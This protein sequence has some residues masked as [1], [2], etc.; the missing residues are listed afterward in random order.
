MKYFNVLMTVLTLI[1]GLQ[2]PVFAESSASE[3][4]QLLSSYRR[5][6]PLEG[7]SNFRDVGGYPTADGK[8]VARGLIFRSGA[9]TSLSESD[10]EYLQQF[11]FKAVVD[12]RSTDER[13]LFVNK[14]AAQQDIPIISRDYSLVK[15]LAKLREQMKGQRMDLA[16]TYPGLLENI[17]PQLKSMFNALLEERTPLVFNCSAGQD[18]TGTTAAILLT[19][20]GV[21][22]DIVIEDYLLST[23]FRRPDRENGDVDLVAAAETNPF[24][25]MM[26]AYKKRSAHPERPNSLISSEGIPY[27]EYTFAWIDENYGSLDNYLESELGLGEEQL[28]KLKTLY[29]L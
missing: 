22:H 3:R 11:D 18:R 17:K 16:A 26:L 15:D 10:V 20:L 21:E 6:L 28:A 29:T 7:G 8:T 19:M 9:M 1:I 5:L 25:K 13:E 12:L 4:E 2:S 23:D 24:A 14:W 27:V